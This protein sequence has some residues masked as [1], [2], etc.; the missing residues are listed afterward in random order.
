MLAIGRVVI[1]AAALALAFKLIL[2]NLGDL[3]AR[4]GSPALLAAAAPFSARAAALAAEQQLG[5]GDAEAAEALARRSLEEAPLSARALR[6]LGFARQEQSDGEGAARYV[7]LAG[8]LGWRD[9]PTQLWLIE[10]YVRQGDFP[11]ALERI[12]ALA[13]RRQLPEQVNALLLGTALDPAARAALGERLAQDPPWRYGFFEAAHQ[14]PPESLDAFADFL[15]SFV[16]AGNALR[17]E[18]VEGFVTNLYQQ[19]QYRRARETW[20]RFAEVG[21]EG[22]GSLLFDGGFDRARLG[23]GPHRSLFEWNFPR[24]PGGEVRLVPPPGRRHEQALHASSRGNA[25]YEVAEQTL[26]LVPG[27]Y[28]LVAD[29][30]AEPGARLEGFS[31]IVECVPSRR[32]LLTDE[33]QDALPDGWARLTRTF[34]VP[35]GC[36]AQRLKLVLRG[37]QTRALDLWFDR[38]A[39]RPAG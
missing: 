17:P 14:L 35:S 19:G 27:R 21:R 11:A 15:A 9:T 10:A 34:E 3:A 13:R 20:R 1:L 37:G 12:D 16:S 18:E 6:T 25:R 23:P 33:R 28:T 24:P 22:A 29:A 26:A 38:V 31:W 4:T 32:T 30:I 7:S 5:A 2:L 36:E 39:V 8:G